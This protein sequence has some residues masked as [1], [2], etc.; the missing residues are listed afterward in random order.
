M[1]YFLGCKDE[2]N[3][4]FAISYIHSHF[5]PANMRRVIDRLSTIASAVV[6][7]NVRIALIDVMAEENHLDTV[8]WDLNSA[9]SNWG[10]ISTYIEDA[11]REEF[12]EYDHLYYEW[13]CYY[14]HYWNHSIAHYAKQVLEQA[15]NFEDS[16][17]I[18]VF[19]GD[20]LFCH[21][22]YCYDYEMEDVMKYLSTNAR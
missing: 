3:I 11:V 16:N 2:T 14:D 20:E 6:S 10:N 17:N 22:C 9:I 19:I 15:N 21:W 5:S 8:I 4:V 13:D 18:V 12:Y 7:G 1:L